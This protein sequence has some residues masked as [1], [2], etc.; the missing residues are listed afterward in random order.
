MRTAWIVVADSSRGYIFSRKNDSFTKV[1]ELSHDEARKHGKDLVTDRSGR[2]FNSQGKGQ[3]AMTPEADPKEHEAQVFSSQLADEIEKGRNANL[4]EDLVLVAP[5][6][7]LGYLRKTL[8]TPTSR[9]VRREINKDLANLKLSEIKERLAS[10]L[11]T[12]ASP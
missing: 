2:A 1:K 3:H 10:E 4:F 5:P 9:L 8:R 7:L 12:P 6:A 11:N